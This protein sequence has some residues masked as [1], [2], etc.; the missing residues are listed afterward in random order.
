MRIDD[1]RYLVA[2]AEFGSINKAAKHLFISQQG[3]SQA[4]QQLEKYFNV[5][6]LTRKANKVYFTEP[7]KKV[8]QFAN[9]VLDKHDELLSLLKPFSYDE[10][11][12]LDKEITMVYSTPFLTA[13][14]LLG[15]VQHF[16]VKYPNFKLQITDKRPSE[17][18]TNVRNNRNII[19]LFNI[20][21]FKFDSRFFEENNLIFEKLFE[22]NLVLCTSKLSPLADKVSVSVNDIAK[23]K[24]AILDFEQEI[25][26]ANYIFANIEKPD[27][28]LKT[29][30]RELYLDTI[31]NGN[32][33]GFYNT[34]LETFINSN[35]VIT[36]PFDPPIKIFVGLLCNNNLNI[37]PKSQ[38]FVKLL[39]QF[40]IKT[41]E[42]R[43]LDMKLNS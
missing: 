25:D 24:F 28:I 34:F 8:L 14:I 2:I 20:P 35:N 7:G 19:G 9:E 29:K 16:H 39:R 10:T 36:I 21:E 42:K 23:S 18:I 40:V 43:M 13:T 12:E 27:L 26:I 5:D 32:A 33:V 4:V 1:L 15:L 41:A 3:L 30:N 22:C 6:L 31:A 17:I 11:A 37:S 38:W